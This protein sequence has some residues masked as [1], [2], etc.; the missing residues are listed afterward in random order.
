MVIFR[1]ESKTGWWKTV[2]REGIEPG[3]LGL[4]AVTTYH[5]TISLV[6]VSGFTKIKTINRDEQS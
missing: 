1:K 3:V 2:P 5:Y 6:P 4:P